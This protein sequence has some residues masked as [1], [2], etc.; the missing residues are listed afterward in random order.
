MTAIPPYPLHWPEGFPRTTMRYPSKFKTT[1]AAATANVA[2]SLKKFAADSR[3][4]V[5]NVVAT[6]NSGGI[7]LGNRREDDPGVAVWFDW[8]GAK[9]CIAVDRY[10]TAAENLQAIHHIIEARRTE[11]RH[12]G[13]VI[14]RSAFK[15]FL[16]LPSP[17]GR[18]WSDELGVER[19]ASAQQIDEAFRSRA[20]L[21]HPDSGGS[22]E[23]MARLSA[24]RE[25]ALAERAV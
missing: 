11:V 13:L 10:P 16:A 14:A 20:K 1:L 6:S 21:A 7:A 17:A 19:T 9:R 18:H 5:T 25:R 4:Q 23:Q 24:A 8:D 12:G 3:S 2:G 15:G 22:H